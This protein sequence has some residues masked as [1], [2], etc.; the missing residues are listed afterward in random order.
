MFCQLCGTEN[1]DNAKFCGSCG[2]KLIAENNSSTDDQHEEVVDIT[3][4]NNQNHVSDL[5]K[6]G[7]LV[8]TVLIPFIGMVMGLIYITQGETDDKKDVG[9]LWLYTS[10]VIIVLYLMFSN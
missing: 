3:H 7:V 2:S 4:D 8:C 10:I 9:K 5:M 6:Y 1:P